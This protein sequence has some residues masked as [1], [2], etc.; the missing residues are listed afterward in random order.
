VA[1]GLSV[2]EIA[3]EVDRSYATVRHWLARHGLETKGTARRRELAEARAEGVAEA[4]LTCPTCGPSR[5]RLYPSR[6]YVCVPCRSLAVADRRRR[7]KAILVA[8]AGGQC[9]RCGFAESQAALQFHHVHPATKEF[10]ISRHGATRS[11][12]RARAEARKCILLCANCH[13]IV[14]AAS[15]ALG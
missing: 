14:E 11:I 1:A 6:G 10:H 3:A 12:D 7:I 13:A 2:R 9:A 15:T 4:L 5:H 8:E